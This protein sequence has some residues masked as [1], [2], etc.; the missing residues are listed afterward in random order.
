MIIMSLKT[1]I[2]AIPGYNDQVKGDDI[3]M[4]LV[5]REVV[6]LSSLAELDRSMPEVDLVAWIGNMEADYWWKNASEEQ[7]AALRFRVEFP[8]RFRDDGYPDW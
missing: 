6:N 4:R 8:G 5:S 7:R 1:E 2:L 3:P